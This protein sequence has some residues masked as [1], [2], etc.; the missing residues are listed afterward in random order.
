MSKCGDVYPSCVNK[1]CDPPHWTCELELGHRGDHESDEAVT[2]EQEKPEECGSKLKFKGG[3]L[4]MWQGN[5]I[6]C[7]RPP[8]HSDMHFRIFDNPDEERVSFRWPQ[9][10]P[11]YNVACTDENGAT[12]KQRGMSKQEAKLAVA[13]V[14]DSQ[15]DFTSIR[16]DRT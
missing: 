8:G 1:K 13:N 5:T 6:A 12:V 11:T 3:G 15:G 2:W 4:K 16:V 7:S 14:L 9:E 10:K